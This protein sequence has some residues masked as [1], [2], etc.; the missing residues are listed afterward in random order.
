MHRRLRKCLPEVT[1]HC[2][3]RC[4][5]LR[6]LF[7]ARDVKNISIKVIRG[8]LER[9]SFELVFLEFVQNHFHLIIRTVENGETVSRIMQYIKSRIAEQYNKSIGRTGPFWNER[10][11]SSIIEECDNP[12]RT[13][14][15]L[16]WKISYNLVRKGVIRNPRENEYGMIRTYLEK[17]YVP[18]V[19][20]TLHK[21][22]L[23]LGQSFED[24]VRVFLDF[25]RIYLLLYPPL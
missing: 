1:Y 10:F 6:D 19:K 16:I 4:V 24:R 15:L 22:F 21:F 12:R 2:Q 14:L 20:I 17:D 18:I 5:E 8:A 11:R 7:D 25:E 3:S 23:D 13:L 9:Y